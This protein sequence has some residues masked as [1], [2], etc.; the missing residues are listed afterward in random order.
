MS[1]PA[2][3][4]EMR[5]MEMTSDGIPEAEVQKIAI[6]FECQLPDVSRHNPSPASF[7]DTVVHIIPHVHEIALGGDSEP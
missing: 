7:N 2:R 6:V 1:T 3:L 5:A 4:S